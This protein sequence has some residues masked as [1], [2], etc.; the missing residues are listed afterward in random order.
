[1]W[2]KITVYEMGVH[3]IIIIFKGISQG[4]QMRY[5]GRDGSMVT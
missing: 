5:V 3:V 2:T 1:M 4:Q